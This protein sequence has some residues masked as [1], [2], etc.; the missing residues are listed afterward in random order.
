MYGSLNDI[1]PDP[2]SEED[3]NILLDLLER[4]MMVAADIAV[5]LLR[6]MEVRF[7]PDAR[8]VIKDI[9]KSQEFSPR[10]K[11]GDPKEDLREFCNI[12]DKMAAGSHRWERVIDESD[13]I[14]YQFTRCM[15]ADIFREL[16]EPELGSIICA[17]DG[18]WVKSYNPRLS[19]KRTKELMGGAEMCDHLFYVEK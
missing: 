6:A 19:F 17:R 13:R 11:V 18:P 5:Q 8:E 9:T 4:K 12:V 7:G 1:L 14:G 10:E 15:Y 2:I 16:G 3:E